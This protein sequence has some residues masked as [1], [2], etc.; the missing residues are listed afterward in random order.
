[1]GHQVFSGKNPLS[2]ERNGPSGIRPIGT[3]IVRPF[4]V[5][6][7]GFDRQM[8]A[9]SSVAY[10]L[11]SGSYQSDGV[12]R[13]RTEIRASRIEHVHHRL[14]RGGFQR[15][16]PDR[17]FGWQSRRRSVALTRKEAEII[18]AF[19]GQHPRPS[20]PSGEPF[21]GD[22]NRWRPCTW[23]RNRDG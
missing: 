19:V 21:R 23:C 9:R 13:G 11:R 17:S 20:G 4:I 18:A 8:P 6:G 7:Y 3:T 12:S 15:Q 14:V 10:E 1:V 2:P 5:S 16:L 22:L